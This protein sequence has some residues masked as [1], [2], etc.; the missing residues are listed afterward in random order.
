MT[1]TIRPT[2]KQHLAYEALRDPLIK[3]VFFGGGAGGGKSWLGCEWLLT[4]CYFYPGSRWFIGRQELKRLMGSS[5]I[6]FNKVCS[7]HQIPKSDWSLNS[8]YNYIE[9][10]NG[11]RI[12]LLDLAHQPSD[13]E[14]QRLGSLE[15]TGGWIEEAGEIN[16]MSFDVL[17]SRVGRHLNKEFNI[18]SKIL[19]TCNPIK[20]WIYQ[21]V[22]KPFKINSLPQEYCFI[23]SLYKDNPFTAEEYGKNLSEI[24]DKVTKERL[25][26]GNWEYDDDETSLISYE[27]IL[28][29][30]TNT[31]IE[32]KNKYI[33]ADIARMGKDTTTVRLWEGLKCYKTIQW[34]KQPLDIT[35]S[36]ISEILSNEQIPFS[37]VIVDEDGV[38]GG[39]VDMLRGVKG[40]INNSTPIEDRLGNTQ[41]FQNLKTQCY[42]KLAEYINDHKIRIEQDNQLI[43]QQEI[44]ELEQ[45]KRKDADKDGKLKIRPK[46]EIKELIGRSP[47]LA[48]SLMMRMWFEFNPV[49]TGVSNQKLPNFNAYGAQYTKFLKQL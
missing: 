43:K 2:L 9:F 41:N 29:L 11:S 45:I 1:P 21:E 35:A 13:P 36:K 23:Q 46:E 20:N 3:Y 27:A 12:D 42:Y 7:F 31:I 19:N 14:Y 5:F 48:D 30:Y 22:Y 47:D 25:M 34:T 33:T 39:V 4:N 26:F 18:P 24:K 44:E 28:D 16:F 17:K 40:F 10:F 6:T 8:K 49:R 15:Y 38:G 37:H 32:D